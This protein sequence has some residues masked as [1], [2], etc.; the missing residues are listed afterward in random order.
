LLTSNIE[1]AAK[2]SWLKK[3]A[4]YHMFQQNLNRN[5]Q[6][7]V[8]IIIVIGGWTAKHWLLALHFHFSPNQEIEQFSTFPQLTQAE[9]YPTPLRLDVDERN[10]RVS[11]CFY[12]FGHGLSFDLFARPG[13]STRR[14][15][16]S[17][18]GKMRSEAPPSQRAK[19]EAPDAACSISAR[20]LH[21]SPQ[22][23]ADDP[24][25]P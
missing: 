11:P 7:A 22:T 5:R 25:V 20:P 23:R 17:K 3:N 1:S 9:G 16:S 2:T 15:F 21:D 12:T 6:I 19:R 10:I 8:T 14:N 13:S 18:T 4:M 24:M